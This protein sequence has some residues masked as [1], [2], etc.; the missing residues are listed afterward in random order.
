MVACLPLRT[1][2]LFGCVDGFI[3]HLP[4]TFLNV[5]EL[6][7]SNSFCLL[8]NILDF[9]IWFLSQLL[10]GTCFKNAQPSSVLMNIMDT[11]Y[12]MKFLRKKTSKPDGLF[13]RISYYPNGKHIA[14]LRSATPNTDTHICTYVITSLPLFSFLY[15]IY[16][17]CNC[18]I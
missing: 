4:A 15:S 14:I 2:E 16:H 18:L 1:Q 5:V 7:A 6:N 13:Q 9:L 8:T 17:I 11:F 12:M 3:L 10:E